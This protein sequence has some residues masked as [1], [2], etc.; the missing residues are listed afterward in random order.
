MK[1]SW[2]S[3]EKL[4][5]FM[6]SLPKLNDV[7]RL[8]K[9]VVRI[10][11][12]NPSPYTLQGTNTYLIGTGPRRILLDTTS[13]IRETAEDGGALKYL[14]N[15]RRFL[16]SENAR[17]S[18]ILITHRHNDHVGTLAEVLRDAA[19]VHDPMNTKCSKHKSHKHNEYT[20]SI[21][22]HYLADGEQFRTEGST[23]SALH[24]PGHTDDLV[25]FI[26][27]EENALFSADHVLGHGSTF[28][29]HLDL[30]MV[31]HERLLKLNETRRF[32]RF[33][34]AHGDVVDGEA[35]V[36]DKI[37]EYMNHRLKRINEISQYVSECNPQEGASAE[38]VLQRFYPNITGILMYGAANNILQALKY[39]AIK[40][41]LESF[42]ATLS[43]GLSETRW[44]K[45]L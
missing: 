22:W 32:R 8:S 6:A 9:S 12:Q 7:E 1:Q 20:E 27:E 11:G 24:L 45:K 35:R 23:I 5:K 25:T 30:Y 26:I 2:Q 4:V 29:E 36:S 13:S 15:L 19:L 14:E 31:S 39:L 38:K 16:A 3:S 21:N 33:Y 43:D 10:L 28:V 42:E 40:G 37:T 17:I 44:R 41:V 18:E 34:P